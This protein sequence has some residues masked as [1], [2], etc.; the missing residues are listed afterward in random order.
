MKQLNSRRA[1]NNKLGMSGGHE[2]RQLRLLGKNGSTNESG[3]SAG[4]QEKRAKDEALKLTK[5]AETELSLARNLL[6]NALGKNHGLDWKGSNTLIPS[7]NPSRHPQAAAL[8]Q[9]SP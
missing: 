5:E 2:F 7:P 9:W 6:G 1:C 4:R 3:M 8:F